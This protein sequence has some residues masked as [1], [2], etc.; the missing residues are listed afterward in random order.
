MNNLCD[1]CYRM[2][3]DMGRDV[4]IYSLKPMALDRCVMCGEQTKDYLVPWTRWEEAN[5]Y[6]TAAIEGGNP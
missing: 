4:E 3:S 5:Y 1:G 6:P 2:L